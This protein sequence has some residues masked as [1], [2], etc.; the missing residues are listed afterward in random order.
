MTGVIHNEIRTCLNTVAKCVRGA[1]NEG[2]PAIGCGHLQQRHKREPNIVIVGCGSDP[3]AAIHE[4][5]FSSVAH[6]SAVVRAELRVDAVAKLP[7]KELDP[8]NATISDE[9]HT[10]Y[11]IHLNAEPEHEPEKHENDGDV[12]KTRQRTNESIDDV[13][14][15]LKLGYQS[16]RSQTSQCT[17]GSQWT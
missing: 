2:D 14:H 16:Q 3:S 1:L 11:Q 12:E 17:N 13:A 6:N 7:P 4:L 5:A 10:C 15:R 9:C 8:K